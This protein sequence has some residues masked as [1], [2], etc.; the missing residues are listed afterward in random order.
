M[1]S[2]EVWAGSE[3]P[4][5]PRIVNAITSGKAKSAYFRMV[6]EPWPDLEFTQINCRKVGEPHTSEEFIQFVERQ[7]LPF[8]RCGMKVEIDGSKAI[9]T[10]KSGAYFRAYFLDH[11]CEGNFHPTW[12]TKYFD[13]DGKLIYDS[14][15][16]KCLTK[17]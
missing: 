16:E 3:K 11:K 17:T 9:I 4:D 8:V 10:R 6:R 13:K 12:K 14:E 5:Y 15:K 1:F 7:G 2:W